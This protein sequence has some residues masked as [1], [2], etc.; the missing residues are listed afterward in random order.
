VTVIKTLLRAVE[1]K[2]NTTLTAV[3]QLCQ[4]DPFSMILLYPDLDIL[5]GMHREKSS[6]EDKLASPSLDMMQ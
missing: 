1:G 5:H 2:S 3:F 6:A 4:Q